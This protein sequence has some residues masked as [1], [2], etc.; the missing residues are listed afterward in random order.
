ML[1]QN[2][3]G[4]GRYTQP[5]KWH[6]RELKSDPHVTIERHKL[7]LWHPYIAVKLHWKKKELK[8]KGENPVWC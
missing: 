7:E 3:N 6:M 8:R 5:V 4:N 1:A 2:M